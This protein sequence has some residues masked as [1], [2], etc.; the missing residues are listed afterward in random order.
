MVTCFDDIPNLAPLT[1][2]QIKEIQDHDSFVDFNDDPE[3]L[4]R[5]VNPKHTILDVRT[6][7]FI[8]LS[9]T[10]YFLL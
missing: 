7:N 6:S 9:S 10:S 2:E 8:S 5:L 3:E 1:K 4:L